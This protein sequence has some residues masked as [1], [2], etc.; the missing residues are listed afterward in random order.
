MEVLQP[1]YVILRLDAPIVLPTTVVEHAIFSSEVA[2]LSRNILMNSD[3]SSV[4]GGHFEI[5]RTLS[6][7]QL[8]VGIEIVGFGQPGVEGRYPVHVYYTP[9]VGGS[10]LAKNTIRQSKQ[11]CLVLQGATAFS[12]EDNVGFD[13]TGHCF[14][15]TDGVETDNSFER[16]LGASIR[17]AVNLIPGEQDNEPSVFWIASPTNS[18]AGNVAAGSEGSGFWFYPELRGL[19]R[20]LFPQLNPASADLLQFSNNVVHSSSK[21]AVRELLQLWVFLLTEQLL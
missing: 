6:G 17:S 13:I 16:N 14:M 3:D 10:V 5:L 11:R 21:I 9:G 19:G 15:T 1:G 12:I 7:P 2:L 18:Y 8:L 4:N 20:T